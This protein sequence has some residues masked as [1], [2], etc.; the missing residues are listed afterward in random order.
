MTFLSPERLWLLT[1]IPLLAAAYAA[2]R[3]RRRRHTVRF[4]NLALLSQVAPRRPGRRRH[5]AAPCSSA[6]PLRCVRGLHGALPAP[7]PVDS[8]PFAL[9]ERRAVVPGGCTC[10]IFA[11]VNRGRPGAL[12]AAMGC[13]PCSD[14][15]PGGG[16]PDDAGD[17]AGDGARFRRGPTAQPKPPRGAQTET[18]WEARLPSAG[19]PRRTAPP[20]R[21]VRA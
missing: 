5:V 10:R 4:A 2:M 17:G 7:A 16:R 21:P 15:W 11:S 14:P 6:C 20:A 19:V 9:D 13:P 8:C 1:L 12:L 3:L 18:R